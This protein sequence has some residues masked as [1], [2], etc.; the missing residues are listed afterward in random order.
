MRER[1]FTANTAWS[2]EFHGGLPQN[3]MISRAQAS[4]L[5][6]RRLPGV[7]TPDQA[8]LRTG[9]S[10]KE[11]DILNTKKVL[12][13]LGR[14]EHRKKIYAT[15]QIEEFLTNLDWLNLA[16]DAITEYW[17]EKNKSRLKPRKVAPKTKG[18][19]PSTKFKKS[20]GTTPT[21]SQ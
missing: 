1:L 19:K 9:F 5:D 12:T 13:T 6:L 21:Q 14:L 3:A 20:D 15:I 2:E 17:I 7:L 10:V 8:S 18:R 11:L 16:K 4:L